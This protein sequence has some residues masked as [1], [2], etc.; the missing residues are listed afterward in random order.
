MQNVEF[1]CELRDPALARIIAAQ[2]GARHVGLLKQIDTYYRVP[3]GRLKKRECE[4]EPT[5]FIFYHRLNRSRPKLSHFTIYSAEEARA[6]FGEKELPSWV[7]VTKQRDLWMYA[8]VRLHI[9]R[10]EGLGSYFEAEAL[11]T[12]A[13]HVG[14]CHE[15]IADVRKHFAP[16]LGELIAT[17]YCD[18]LANEMEMGS[19]GVG[20]AGAPPVG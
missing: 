9:D 4:G 6:R 1:K 8:G 12:P 5:E 11:V 10:V 14:R 13:Q 17:S 3:D 15:A 18:L 2:I 20:G 19:A 7:V 16:A